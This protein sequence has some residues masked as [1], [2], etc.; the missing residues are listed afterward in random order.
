MHAAVSLCRLSLSLFCSHTVQFY[1]AH[2]STFTVYYS[3][4]SF[5]F[6]SSPALFGIDDADDDDAVGVGFA[7]SSTPP[8]TFACGLPLACFFHDQHYTASTKGNF[9]PP[10]PAVPSATT[11][12]GAVLGHQK[13]THLSHRSE[14]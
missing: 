11:A 13:G 6:V 1:T 7:T 12:T 3:P 10:P 8:E 4:N 9:R 2:Y 14:P 5:Q